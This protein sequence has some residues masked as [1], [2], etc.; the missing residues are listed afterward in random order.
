MPGHVGLELASRLQKYH[1]ERSEWYSLLKK[2]GASHPDTMAKFQ[3][4]QAA[5]ME[6]LSYKAM[7]E[8]GT[9]TT[10]QHLECS[11]HPGEVLISKGYEGNTDRVYCCSMGHCFTGTNGPR[12]LGGHCQ[13]TG[14]TRAYNL[15]VE[16]DGSYTVTNDYRGDKRQ[17]IAPPQMKLNG[18]WVGLKDAWGGITRDDTSGIRGEETDD[19]QKT[20]A[21]GT[22]GALEPRTHPAQ[23]V[24]Q[25]APPA[26]YR[27]FNEVP[28]LP[29]FRTA[30]E[31]LNWLRKSG[32]TRYVDNRMEKFEPRQIYSICN[33]IHKLREVYPRLPPLDAIDLIDGPEKATS[34]AGIRK[35]GGKVRLSIS[36]KFAT[37]AAWDSYKEI[38]RRSIRKRVRDMG[39]FLR[40]RVA[41]LGGQ[42]EKNYKLISIPTISNIER[43]RAVADNKRLKL[44]LDKYRNLLM[45][46]D[47]SLGG[48]GSIPWMVS[49][50]IGDIIVHEMGHYMHLM[51]KH[52]KYDTGDYMFGQDLLGA[53]ESKRDAVYGAPLSAEMVGQSYMVS[54]YALTNTEELLAEC[55]VLYNRGTHTKIPP[56]VLRLLE[57]MVSYHRNG[58]FIT[59][60]ERQAR[61][62]RS[63]AD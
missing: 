55:F 33:A 5:W 20:P 12:K 41:D 9:S 49:E 39:G 38:E 1:V 7:G 8:I 13:K 61:G 47:V 57:E 27:A 28:D 17:P 45:V 62:P 46:N 3:R 18:E 24:T 16:E 60:P 29:M 52:W 59:L 58:T 22:I 56:S 32:V 21:E 31:G 11:T 19:E 54:D 14:H 25:Q 4:S 63:F 23:P 43:T 48:I 26:R 50:S 36:D 42:I 51:T 44:D 30:R 34:I 37:T 40:G 10:T 6:Y 35:G 15:S 2:L 53:D